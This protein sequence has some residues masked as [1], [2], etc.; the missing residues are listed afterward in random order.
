MSAGGTEEAGIKGN[1]KNA[2][3]KG[4]KPQSSKKI[5]QR[6]IRPK[7]FTAKP[8]GARKSFYKASIFSWRL[9]VFA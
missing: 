1:Q 2:S 4:A 7:D 8:Q 5:K 9:G 3:R 6:H